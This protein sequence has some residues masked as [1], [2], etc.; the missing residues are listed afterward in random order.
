MAEYKAEYTR[1]STAPVL[2]SAGGNDL[3][4]VRGASEAHSLG[5]PGT[6][7]NSGPL[8]LH[9]DSMAATS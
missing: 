9:G 6:L 8:H 3:P 1:Q 2:D 4:L 5:G 7:E